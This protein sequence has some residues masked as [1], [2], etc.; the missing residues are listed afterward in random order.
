MKVLITGVAGQDGYYMTK[1]MLEAGNEVVG[2][3]SN[4]GCATHELRALSSA[5]LAIHEF[6]YY[7]PLGIAG[8]IEEI[9][10]DV[11]FNFAARATGQ[12]MF[13]APYELGRL[14]GTFVL[15]VL[16]AIRQSSRCNEISFCQASSSE[17]YGTVSEAPQTED[18]P[19]RPKSPYGAAK[20]YAHNMIGIY[21][22]TYGIKACSAILYNHESV[23]RTTNFVTKKIAN[24]VAA[25]KLGMSDSLTL[26]ALD[27]QRDWGYAPEYVDAMYRMATSERTEDYV[28]STGVLHSVRDL[29]ESAFGYVDL[30]YMDYVVTQQ[31]HVREYESVNLLGNPGKISEHLG[32]AAKKSIK[33]VM[34]ELV[35]YELDKLSQK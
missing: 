16:E 34:K 32:W 5:R 17:M 4:V 7:E 11:F 2:L 14:N 35:D 3:T 10:P 15:D 13:D 21:R 25:I 6:D 22:S 19:F 9:S 28:V 29:C 27:S 30:D 26:G 23:R 8:I 31:S 1:Q 18:S 20:L 33:E 24:A 12:G